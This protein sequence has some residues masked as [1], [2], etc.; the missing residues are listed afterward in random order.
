M[1]CASVPKQ[2]V[3]IIYKTSNLRASYFANAI[4]I[5]GEGV[6]IASD[7]SSLGGGHIARDIKHVGLQGAHYGGPHIAPIPV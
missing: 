5:W 4:H 3:V 2:D 1:H 7:T 6:Q